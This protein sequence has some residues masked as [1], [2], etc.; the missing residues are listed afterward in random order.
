MEFPQKLIPVMDFAWDSRF[1]IFLVGIV[2]VFC[3]GTA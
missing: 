3:L 1:G 2:L